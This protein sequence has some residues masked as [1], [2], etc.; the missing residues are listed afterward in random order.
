MCVWCECVGSITLTSIDVSTNCQKRLWTSLIYSLCDL[1]AIPPT[2]A[3]THQYLLKLL[4]SLSILP[5]IATHCRRSEEVDHR[6]CLTSSTSSALCDYYATSCLIRSHL[7]A[8]GQVCE[9]LP[10][11]TPL[12]GS[13][14]LCREETEAGRGIESSHRTPTCFSAAVIL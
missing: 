13:L 11:P 12:C 4:W 14:T 6:V 8:A 3:L 9:P 10:L 7:T 5:C 2:S 1:K